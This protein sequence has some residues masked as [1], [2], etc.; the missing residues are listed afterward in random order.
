MI[1]LLSII[2]LLSMITLL[3]LARMIHCS[4]L[5]IFS[6]SLLRHTLPEMSNVI[7]SECAEQNDVSRHCQ[8]TSQQVFVSNPQ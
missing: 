3:S 1:T 4:S 7:L 8:A 5:P 2:T 6:S